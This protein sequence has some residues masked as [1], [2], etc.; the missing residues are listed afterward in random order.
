MTVAELYEP[1]RFRLVERP[2]SDPGHGEVQVRVESIGICGSDVHYFS[3]GGIGDTPCVYPMVL[4]HE[5][6][7]EVVRVG[8]GVSGWAPGDRAALEP[9]IY[10]YHCEFCLSGRHNVCNNMRVLSTPGDPGFFRDHVNLP[11]GNLLPLPRGLGLPEA[12]LFEPLAVVLHSMQFVSLAIGENAVVFGAGPIGLLT[13]GVLKLAGSAR[14]WAV[15]PMPHRREMALRAGADAVIDP[16]A[17]DPSAQILADT[18]QRGADVAIDCVT[19]DDSLNHAI[20]ATRNAG[21][22]VVTGIPSEQRVALEFHVLRRKE[23]VFYNVRRSAHESQLALRMLADYPKQFAPIVT[24][25]RPLDSIEPAFQ[26]LESYEDGV[27]KL[28]LKPRP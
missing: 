18:G 4:G 5:P 24:H 1:R 8:P 14:I 3:E 20:R 6:A 12:T 17:V 28:I 16:R 7:G 27:G 10:C 26:M 9:A 11:A 13:I 22:V 23:L 19:K 21:R 15:E 25:S 2:S